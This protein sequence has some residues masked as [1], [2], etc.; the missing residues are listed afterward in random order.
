[1]KSVGLV[2]TISGSYNVYTII[3]TIY[4]RIVYTHIVYTHDMYTQNLYTIMY[5]YTQVY[6]YNV[7]IIY[8]YIVN[9]FKMHKYVHVQCV[10]ILILYYVLIKPQNNIIYNMYTYT[11]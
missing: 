10:L 6:T 11:V 7:Y 8:A 3:Y 2:L 5:V 1:M 9:I 4:T